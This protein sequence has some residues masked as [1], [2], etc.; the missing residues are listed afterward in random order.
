M[1]TKIRERLIWITANAAPVDH[2]VTD[3]GMAAG[4]A[5]QGVYL[6]LC[7]T[8]FVSAPMTATPGARCSSCW[9]S[10]QAR[11]SLPTVDQRLNGVRARRLPLLG[12]CA[13]FL[14]ALF[15]SHPS[16]APSPR[17]AAAAA[18]GGPPSGADGGRHR[19]Q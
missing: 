11:T 2:A 18:G 4:M 8:Q 16:V 14:A 15:A 1:V 3:A 7:G 9:R 13:R 10:A 17:S 6:G 5:S 12:A 19:L